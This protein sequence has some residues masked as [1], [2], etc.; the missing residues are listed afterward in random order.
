MT[1]YRGSQSV[2]QKPWQIKP[3][4]TSVSWSVQAE[5]HSTIVCPAFSFLKAGSAHHHLV[6][7]SPG[8]ILVLCITTL[9]CLPSCI[10]SLLQTLSGNST[11]FRGGLTKHVSSLHVSYGRESCQ[12]TV[13]QQ[14]EFRIINQKP[15]KK[16]LQ[17]FFV[18]P[19]NSS[20]HT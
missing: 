12:R 2:Q 13:G 17:T 11:E 5:R 6:Q 14:P 7:N 1:F 15:D 8:E 20:R 19:T 10:T 18:S 16:C 4:S 3:S 9:P